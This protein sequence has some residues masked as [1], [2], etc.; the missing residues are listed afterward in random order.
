MEL[1]V[2]LFYPPVK[3]SAS[4]IRNRGFTSKGKEVANSVKVTGDRW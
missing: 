3:F 2:V 1:L 4:Y